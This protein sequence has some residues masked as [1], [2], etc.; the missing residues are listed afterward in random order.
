MNP[1]ELVN[2]CINASPD[3]QSNNNVVSS[4]IADKR[5]KTILIVV[6][7]IAVI[8]FV[9]IIV[10]MMVRKNKSAALEKQ[11]QESE[12][13]ELL[14]RTMQ[15]QKIMES[16]DKINKKKEV[17]A[18]NFT[19]ILTEHEK[20]KNEHATLATPAELVSSTDIEE[21]IVVDDKPIEESIDDINNV[22]TDTTSN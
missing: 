20:A 2:E 16:K 3:L 19:K 18:S 8:I 5:K 7:V 12:R 9:G 21:P 10:Y 22:A 1:T 4:N 15:N 11:K 14:R 17:N 13:N 6:A